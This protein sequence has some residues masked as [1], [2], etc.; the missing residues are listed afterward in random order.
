MG[1]FMKSHENIFER[2]TLGKLMIISLKGIS[3]VMLIENTLSGL[4]ILIAIT[5]V[6]YQLGILTFLSAII[7]TLVAYVAGG[8]RGV[9]SQGLFGYNSVLVGQALYLFLTGNMRFMIAL[10]AAALVAI[11]TA[12]AM[13][14]L[15]GTG[16]PILTFPYIVLA[17][18]L[19][20]TSY[21]L[22]SFQLHSSLVPRSLFQ[23]G[24]DTEVIVH[25]IDGVVNG[26][27]QVYFQG[28]LL[29]GILIIISVFWENWKLGVYAMIGSLIAWMS[30]YVL[31]ADVTALNLGLYG[32]NAVLTMLAVAGVFDADKP[33]APLT[34]VIAA[35]V[36][37]PITASINTWL[38]PYGLTALTMPFVLVTWTFLSA[39]KVLP[40]L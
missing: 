17:W 26:I 30:A 16:I 11:F 22:N 20:L 3:Q 13:H 14:I 15:K 38:M 8:D 25:F 36:T 32:Y 31:E 23:I 6:D 19:L 9:I 39:R 27:G 5:I 40:K 29:S 35:A 18:F 7:G 28:T 2:I 24:I 10:A 1:D 21:Q 4:L 33:I 37:V 12:A 34:G